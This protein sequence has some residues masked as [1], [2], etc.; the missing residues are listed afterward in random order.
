M[1]NE[2]DESEMLSIP[3]VHHLLEKERA[4]RGELSYEQK[5][6]LEHAK[7]FDRIGSAEKA[8][9]LIAE[10]TE[11]DRVSRA[12]AIKIADLFPLDVEELRTVFAEDRQDLSDEDAD[13]VMGILDD[14]R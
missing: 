1:A 12:Q 3:E 5:L 7:A 6:S 14:Y 2:L 13:T 10:L 4:E 9:K 11:L 8:K